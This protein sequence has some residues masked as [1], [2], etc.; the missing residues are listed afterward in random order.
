MLGL[1]RSKVLTI[2]NGLTALRIVCLPAFARLARRPERRGQAA[3]VLG[4]LGITDGLDGYIA[5][6]FD[7]GS[8]LGKVADPLVDR[9]FVVTAMR[10]ALATGAVPRWLALTVG[11]REVTAAAGAGVAALTGQEP[12]Q[13]SRL[14]KAGAFAMMAAFPLFILGTVPRWHLARRFAWV[15]AL[16]GQACAWAA[17]AGYV[18]AFLG[19]K[20]V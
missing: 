8:D 13:V 4:L 1:V 5:R 2:P 20:R 14:G 16:A 3:V 17:L 9:A 19:G 15:F 10:A 12:L 7:Q 18:R 11:A 6:R